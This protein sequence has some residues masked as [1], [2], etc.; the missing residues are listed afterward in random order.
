[1]RNIRLTVEYEGTNYAGWQIQNGLPTVQGAL[2]D[3]A[4]ELTGEE[5]V[6]RGASRTD[7]GVHALGQVACFNTSSTISA[8]SMPRALNS[9]LP[10]DIVVVEATDAEAAFDPRRHSKS[11]T[12]RYRI[13]NRPM[14]S[15]LHARFS[16]FVY[17]PLDIELMRKAAAH[18]IGEKDFASF[19]AAH[20]D[21]AHSVREVTGVEIERKGEEIVEIEVRGTAFL[22]HM[23]R[24]MV[25]T[26]VEA[27]TGKLHPDRVLPILDAKDRRVARM[28]APP[29]G[30]CLVSIEY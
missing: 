6:V 9:K 29:Q 16:W 26:L 19:M 1:M 15:A 2:A 30:L 3:A 12:Y 4:S 22:R 8:S 11:K 27:G 25:G 21:A 14:P 23:V 18:F 17:E 10:G 13:L 20:S 7:A 28:T 24:I 5:I